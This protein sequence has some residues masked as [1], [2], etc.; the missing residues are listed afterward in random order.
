M[1]DM[2]TQVTNKI[3]NKTRHIKN[4]LSATFSIL[5]GIIK[6]E[7]KIQ[8]TVAVECKNLMIWHKSNTADYIFSTVH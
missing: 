8:L 6:M 7:W 1:G 5:F 2:H 3:I 4:R